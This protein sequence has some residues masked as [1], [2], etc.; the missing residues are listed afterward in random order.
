MHRTGSL[1]ALL[2][3]AAS[4]PAIAQ[5]VPVQQFSRP[6]AE[7]PD[8]FDQV[9]AVR[10]LRD[11]RLIVADLF[12]RAVSLVDLKSGSATVIGREG[13]GP[14]EYGF[15]TGL[16]ALPHDTTWVVDP[17]QSRFLVILPDGTP[18]GTV[19]FPDEFGG[20][21]RVKG[22]DAR[23]RIYAQGTGFTLGPSSG[24]ARPGR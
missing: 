5:Q 13:Q 21:A 1:S 2:L 12:A 4:V 11:G 20:M 17:A 15:P 6:E 23:G 22:A 16:V 10:E 18:S 7:F 14:N 19:A 24:I 9:T 8:P 3:L